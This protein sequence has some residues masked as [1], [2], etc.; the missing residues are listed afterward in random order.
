MTP[1]TAELSAWVANLQLGDVPPDVL[2][3]SKLL[4]ADITG[5][6]LLSR[7]ESE[8]TPALIEAVHRLGLDQGRFRAISDASGYTATGA[9]LVTGTTA[10]S[11]DFDDTHVRSLHHPSAPVIPAALVAA[12][13]V[14]ASGADLLLG[15]VTGVETMC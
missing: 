4:L 8:S 1:V 12:Q 7:H 15:I 9:A 14:N 5:I 13:M 2:D 10:H 3:K 6:C 11:I